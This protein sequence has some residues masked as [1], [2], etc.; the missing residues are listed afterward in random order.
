MAKL[1]LKA[2]YY[3]A[4]SK[5][6]TG[7]SRGGYAKYIAT[8]DGVE[9]LPRSGMADYIGERKGSNG[10]FSDAGEP[11]VLSH[12][13]EELDNHTGN[14]WGLIFSL[15]REDADRLGYNS[16]EQWMNLLRSRRNDIAKEMHIAPSNLR[17]Y[18]AYHNEKD[19]PHV[20]MLVWSS[21]PREPYLSKFGIE[22]IKKNVSDDI[23]RDEKYHIYKKQTATRDE[24]KEVFRKRIAEITNELLCDPIKISPELVVMFE[25]LTEEIAK[26]K[27]KKVYGYL[28]KKAKSIVDNIVKTIADDEKIAELYDLWYRLQCEVFKTYT[29]KMP[30]KIPL[31]ENK[32][33]KSLRNFVVKTTAEMLP[34]MPVGKSFDVDYKTPRE[35]DDDMIRLRFKA[36]DGNVNAMYRLARRYLSDENN[37]IEAEHWLQKASEKGNV[38]AMYFLY[39]CYRDGRI[40]DHKSKKMK[41]L[42]MAVD[43]NFA[44][45]EYDF[46]KYLESKNDTMAIEYLRQAAKHGCVQAEYAIGK[47][48]LQQGQAEEGLAYLE[49]AA[50]KDSWSKFNLG[51]MYCYRLG[52]W[53]KGIEHLRSAADSGY[54]PARNAINNIKKGLNAKIITGICDLFYYASRIIDD[55]AESEYPHPAFDSVEARAKKED[56]AKRMGIAYSDM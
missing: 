14:V 45:A 5:T 35:S 38:Y 27:G 30:Q 25:D 18:A 52:E 56:Q 42:L 32:E 12:I 40:K 21:D 13:E 37:E 15:K 43:K 23:F 51:L 39:Q 46:G 49:S 36:E 55:R 7:A 53:E 33:F 29:D 34:D 41:Y 3:K 11:I 10:L 4:F 2:P 20:H 48:M 17:W 16:A 9:I 28:S 6:P 22:N 44:Y 47:R 8:R 50:S 26:H 54:E 1:I 19:H 31:E 24:L